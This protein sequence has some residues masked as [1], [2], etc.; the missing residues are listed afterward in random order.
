M[1]EVYLAKDKELGRNVAIKLLPEYFVLDRDRL[2]R[3]KQE[4]RTASALNHPNVCVIYEIS[5]SENGRPFIAMEYIDGVTLRQRLSSD[6]MG[7][8]EAIETTIQVAEALV[9]AHAAGIAH[10]DIKPENIMLR[11]DGYV[12]VLDFG[13]AK[14]TEQKEADLE[15]SARTLMK[16]GAGVVMGTVSYMSP[17]QARALRVDARTDIW[18]LGVVLY[19]MLEG[20][21]P[22]QGE[23]A[24]H[25]VV[26]ILEHEPEPLV[27]GAPD[28]P[29]ALERIVRKALAKNR[30]ERYQT[31]RELLAD[32]KNLRRALEMQSGTERSISPTLKAGDAVATADQT[33]HVTAGDSAA[34]ATLDEVMASSST[35][36]VISRLQSHKALIFAALVF[37]VVTILVA[38]NYFGPKNIATINSI[39]VLPLTNVGGDPNAEYL[40][41]GVTE[42]L[43]DSLSQLPN[44]A[45]KSRSSVFR[46]K[47]RE[48]DPQTVG[49]ELDVQAVLNGRVEQRGD[50]LSINL[51]LVD[52]RN[53]NH[54]WGKQYNRKLTDILTIRAEVVREVSEKLRPRLTGAEEQRATR[55]YTQD[56]EAYQLYLKGRY[57][58]NKR[59]PTG[60][61]KSIE[62]YEQAIAKDPSYAL[63]YS[64]LADS[65]IVASGLLSIVASGL[66]PEEKY[67]KAKAAARKA[68]EIDDTL[69]EPHA[70][71]ARALFEGDWKVA[72]AEKEYQQ[73]IRISPNYATGHQFYA[74]FLAGTGRSD[75]AIAEAQRAQSLDPI[76]L[77]INASLGGVYLYAG[78]SDEALVQFQR[79]V[80]MDNG[81]VDGHEGLSRT[82]IAKG[83]DDEAVKESLN[84]LTLALGDSE[85]VVA[86]R[87]AYASSGVKGFWQKRLA[88]AT[89]QAK[90]NYVSPLLFANLESMLGETD[91]ALEWLERGYQER[92][93]GLIY[94]RVG[95]TFLRLRSN[96]RLK[97]L[98]RRID[99]EYK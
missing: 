46:Y 71:L 80:E 95:P 99:E 54:I 92:T 31:A 19:E 4:A 64:G 96:P 77:T 11:R 35:V 27:K 81:F 83:M 5:E 90:H 23:T 16:T 79:I 94:I 37:A 56:T 7:L 78:K 98:V 14:L 59:N 13:L 15:Q 51:E 33:G 43:I 75:E 45:V 47:G 89:E 57:Y 63:A 36:N 17:E 1:G 22:F 67:S 65:Y 9:A 8:A 69:A 24:S 76:S 97:D 50:A 38:A 53:D 44:L 87:K 41:D 58:W 48:I 70:A 74:L 26:S 93:P 84:A 32:L 85:T 55:R 60:I 61:K 28:S 86:L 30:D 39:A 20:Q 2:G 91:Q 88:L 18:S 3:F 10:R 42:S 62:Y 25:I 66:S 52:A 49:K 82:Y 68:L 34:Q 6:R 40:S 72:E 73:A 12:K 29:A 21:P